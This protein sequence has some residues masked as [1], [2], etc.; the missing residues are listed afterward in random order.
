MRRVTSGGLFAVRFYVLLTCLSIALGVV[1]SL[2]GAE[3]FSEPSFDG[4]RAIVQWMPIEEHYVWG[5]M[6]LVFSLALVGA[7]GRGVAIHVL[8]V[9]LVVYFFLA[10]GFIGSAIVEPTASLI[11]SVVFLGIGTAHALL[12]DHFDARGWEG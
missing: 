11:L 9:G 1:V 5:A 7:L 4:P 8:R 10:A 12:A 2:G 3:R 6:L